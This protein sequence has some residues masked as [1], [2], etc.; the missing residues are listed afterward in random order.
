[1]TKAYD[2]ME[3][4][5]IREVMKNMNF[6]QDFSE[7]IMKCISSVT[8]SVLINGKQSEVFTPQRG[9]RQGDPLS[10]YILILCAEVFRLF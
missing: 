7:L 6:P 1:M 5:F 9:L 10:A 4:K 3:W 2:R 8:Y